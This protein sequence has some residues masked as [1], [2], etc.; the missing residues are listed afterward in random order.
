MA[1]E[2]FSPA[3]RKTMLLSQET[4]YGLRMTSMSINY[5]YI[6]IIVPAAHSFIELVRYQELLSSS[7]DGYGK[8]QSKIFLGANDKRGEHMTTLQC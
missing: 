3:Q 4:R 1:R 6:S 7:A 5:D 2:G 8:I